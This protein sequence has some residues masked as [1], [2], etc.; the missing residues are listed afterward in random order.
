MSSSKKDSATRRVTH[1]V[2]LFDFRKGNIWKIR[3]ACGHAAIRS[4][5]TNK[6]PKYVRRCFDCVLEEN[7]K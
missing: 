7:K 4:R 6:A 1:A 2:A 5:K 3:L